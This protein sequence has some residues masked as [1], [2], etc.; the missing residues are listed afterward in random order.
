MR[1]LIARLCFLFVLTNALITNSHAESVNLTAGF[2]ALSLDQDLDGTFESFGDAN[3]INEI[4]RT[5]GVV[6]QGYLFEFDVSGLDANS[7]ITSAELLFT[8]FDEQIFPG[9]I[10][11]VAFQA[12]GALTLPIEDNQPS[13]FI[14]GYD[15]GSLG[16]GPVSVSLDT[17]IL[18]VLATSGDVIGVRMQGAENDALT[19]IR[20]LQTTLPGNPPTLS[21][22]V[23]SVPEPTTLPFLLATAI[24]I[25]LRWRRRQS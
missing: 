2:E 5:D 13:F 8:V 20:G 4:R 12:D 18:N 25:V 6:N 17:S 7:T 21:L 14:G 23:T 1:I 19:T 16:S 9:D 3:N 10:A 24:P 11:I 15:P 22:N